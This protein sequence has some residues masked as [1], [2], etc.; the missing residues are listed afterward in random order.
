[1]SA[2]IYPRTEENRRKISQKLLGRHNSSRTEFKKDH[3]HSEDI[4]N[5]ISKNRKGKCCGINHPTFGKKK[6]I[7]TREKNR[8]AS[9]GNTYK[10]GKKVKDTSKMSESHIGLH[11][12][13]KTEWKAGHRKGELPSPKSCYG[14]GCYYQ[15]RFQG[16]IWLRSTYELAYAKWLDSIEKDWLY[17]PHAFDLGNTTYTPDFFLIKDNKFIEIKGYLWNNAKIKIDL[18]RKE[19]PN[20]KLDILYK[21]DLE[22]IGAIV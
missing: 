8:Q 21:E 14:K 6:S 7:E 22:K 9:L 12:S 13:P 15:N 17:E 19:Y 3:K 11:C 5:K 4:L 1:M 18:F 16:K 2:G 20:E 10:R